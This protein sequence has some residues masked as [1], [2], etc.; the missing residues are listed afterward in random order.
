MRQIR[1]KKTQIQPFGL[2]IAQTAPTSDSFK[3]FLRFTGE[4][5]GKNYWH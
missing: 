4:E 3:H 1:V 5:H 2:E